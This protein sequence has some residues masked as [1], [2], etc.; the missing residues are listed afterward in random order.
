M[1]TSPRVH[2]RGW[3]AVIIQA[4]LEL[5]IPNKLMGRSYLFHTTLRLERNFDYD[6]KT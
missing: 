5:Y 6:D 2:E 3:N 1:N 4:R